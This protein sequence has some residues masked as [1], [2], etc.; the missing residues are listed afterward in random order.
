MP[1]NRFFQ[2][3]GITVIG[4]GL[5]LGTWVAD[6]AG[7]KLPYW[8][9]IP[10]GVL[11]FLMIFGGLILIFKE[12]TRQTDTSSPSTFTE[13]KGVRG[14]K[15][16]GNRSTGERFLRAEGSSD[17]EVRDNVHESHERAGERE[18]A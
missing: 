11:A 4:A 10:L 12:R 2:G 15:I 9:W 6:Q 1:S 8:L 13:L 16:S 7:L 18:E 17:L 14:A 5:G 3:S